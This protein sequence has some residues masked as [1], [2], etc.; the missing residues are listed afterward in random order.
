MTKICILAGNKDEAVKWASGQNL[1]DD[2]W[3][4]PKD[5]NDLL[6]KSNFHTLVIGTAGMNISSS[7]FDKVYNLAQQRG[8][9]GR[10]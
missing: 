7:Y 4:Y 3:F 5:T 2:Q 10:L 1:N 8:R 9:I 6:F